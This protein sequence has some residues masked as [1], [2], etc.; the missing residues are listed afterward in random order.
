MEQLDQKELARAMNASA[1]TERVVRALT[2][3]SAEV[4]KAIRDSSTARWIAITALVIS[5]L[6]VGA[7]VAQLFK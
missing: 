4:S 2:Q 6:S 5:G 7:Q 1:N 3:Q